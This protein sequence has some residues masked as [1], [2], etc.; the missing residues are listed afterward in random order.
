M[1]LAC[2]VFFLMLR[3]PP[4]STRTDTLFPYTTLFRSLHAP[5]RA[6]QAGRTAAGQLCAAQR[7]SAPGVA[8]NTEP[9]PPGPD[10]DEANAATLPPSLAPRAAIDALMAQLERYGFF[11]AARL[12]F[13]THGL[14]D[15]REIGRAHV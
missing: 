6:Q 13:R 12:L 4:R 14:T 3:R 9:L 5:E 15:L 7:W 10:D 11:Q 1:G 8:M 2:C